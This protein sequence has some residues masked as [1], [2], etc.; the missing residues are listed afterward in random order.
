M[1]IRTVNI[2][3]HNENGK[4]LLDQRALHEIILEEKENSKKD[5][6]DPVLDR[7]EVYKNWSDAVS[8]ERKAWQ[9]KNNIIGESLNNDFCFNMEVLNYYEERI[10][11]L[12]SL[13]DKAK[14]YEELMV[15]NNGKKWTEARQKID[16]LISLGNAL[17]LVKVNK[18]TQDVE[19]N[20]KRTKK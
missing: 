7:K 2:P 15:L 11:L 10:E 13:V 1:E 19:F 12:L 8:K 18:E 9:N 4:I 3:T 6:E 14:K 5:L 16:F 20:L 17:G